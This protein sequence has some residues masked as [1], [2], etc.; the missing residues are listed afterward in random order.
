MLQSV[1]T[2][3]VKSCSELRLNLSGIKLKM[4]EEKNYVML[5]NC[6]AWSAEEFAARFA[7]VGYQMVSAFCCLMVKLLA[8]EPDA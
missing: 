6:G 8:L 4:S 3:F 2:K 7:E 5:N 1:A